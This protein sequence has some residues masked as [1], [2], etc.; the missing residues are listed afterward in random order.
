MASKHQAD[1]N[2]PSALKLLSRVVDFYRRAFEGEPRGAE[3]L[4]GQG[5]KDR[6][7]Y[8]VFRV[9]LASGRLRD[10]LPRGDDSDVARGL[11]ELGILTATGTERFLGCVV[12]PCFDEE[13]VPVGMYGR[14]I[15]EGGA[16]E[17]Y[18]PGCKRGLAVPQAAR[19]S[20]EL[21][22]AETII[23]GMALWDHGFTNVLCCHGPT[24]WTEAH[25]EVVEREQVRELY[26]CFNGRPSG[27]E[28]GSRLAENLR[29]RGLRTIVVPMLQ[30]SSVVELLREGGAS[31]IEAA[32]R[33]A[34]PSVAE[35][36]SFPFH[37]S[38][39]GYEKTS[40]G[41]RLV[42]AAR[43]YEVKGIG[44]SATHLRCAVRAQAGARF[45]LDTVDLYNAKSRATWVHACVE[46]F[47]MDAA[48]AE[49][50]LHRLIEYA[51][52]E[53]TPGQSEEARAGM[54]AT[55]AEEAEARAWLRRPD[56]LDQ[57]VADMDMAGYAG[58]E[59]NKLLG[60]LACVSRK[61]DDPLSLLI[62]SRSAAGKSSLADMLLRMV[63]PEDVRRYTR[64]TEQALYYLEENGLAHK[65]LCIEE[66]AGAEN[67]AYS[68]RSLQSARSLT[69]AV[70]AKDA[71]TGRICTEEHT[72]RGPAMFVLTT[73]ATEIEPETQSRFLILTVDESDEMTARIHSLQRAA[74]TF[75]GLAQQRRREAVI[76]RHHVAQRVLRPMRVVIPYAPLLR[77][78]SK[79]LRTRRDH[80]KYLGLIEAVT[81]LHQCQRPVREMVVDGE[82]VEYIEATLADLA[83]AN[84]LACTV[85]ER[86]LDDLSAQA[87]RL[88]GEIHLLCREQAAA[89]VTAQFTFTR[90]EL[91][92]RCGWSTW[93]L[94]VHLAELQREECV[95]ALAGDRGHRYVYRLQVDDQG[96]PVDVDLSTPEEIAA[97][98]ARLGIEVRP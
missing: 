10:T 2:P 49:Q 88:L 58:E 77:F 23:D 63:P 71:K 12:V 26:I 17:V 56:L 9:G 89:E 41:F 51:E 65:V 57:V 54:L 40:G 68:I 28:N 91:K 80:R 46:L 95:E 67:A 69:V 59:A 30:G 64:I 94:R 24:G 3:Y 52:A 6:A 61:L 97:D 18:L 90:R 19:T 20:K 7:T 15:V 33:Q 79:P 42:L 73:T 75:D 70:T 66:A 86:T 72:V 74:C 43:V 83:A 36:P 98:A 38:H 29:A 44:R 25:D 11:R 39:H 47:A 82:A 96:K 14:R 22:V 34:D 85:L 31:G 84:R 16:T 50:D 81:F 37:R 92:R 4:R 1:S 13:G 53:S 55:P 93:Q 78:P 62:Q 35:R 60:Y 76:R 21:I 5:I 45:H 27:R 48:D 8:D 87:R 32:L